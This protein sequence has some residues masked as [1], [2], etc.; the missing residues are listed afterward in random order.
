MLMGMSRVR[1]G[2][3]GWGSCPSYL[4]AL[5]LLVL[6]GS[7]TGSSQGRT[8]PSPAATLWLKATSDCLLSPP[9]LV[10]FLALCT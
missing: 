10:S 3:R 9:T 7:G 8:G 2:L 6:L 5:G 1:L 4:L